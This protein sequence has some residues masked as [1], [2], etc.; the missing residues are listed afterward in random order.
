VYA[1]TDSVVVLDN[2]RVRLKTFHAYS[3]VLIEGN[4]S[5]ITLQNTSI[6]DAF[7]GQKLTLLGEDTVFN[8]NRVVVNGLWETGPCVVARG[9][10]NTYVFQDS[11]LDNCWACDCWQAKDLGWYWEHRN[12][13]YGSGLDLQ[14]LDSDLFMDS[15]VLLRHFSREGGGGVYVAG[16]GMNATISNTEMYD[17]YGRD[18]GGGVYF[19]AANSALQISSTRIYRNSARDQ[20]TKG[21]GILFEPAGAASTMV[22]Q[23]SE[24][25][26]NIAPEGGGVYVN[27]PRNARC[28]VDI[29]RT[30]ITNNLAGTNGGGLVVDAA[31]GTVRVQSC[32]VS[33]NQGSIGGGVHVIDGDLICAETTVAENLASQDGGGILFFPNNTDSILTLTGVTINNN[34]ALGGRGGGLHVGGGCLLANQLH[35]ISNTAGTDGGGISVNGT[36]CYRRTTEDD[37]QYPALRMQD[38][39][40]Q[41]NRA[42]M[43]GGGVSVRGMLPAAALQVH[44]VNGA[45][46]RV[47]LDTVYVRGLGKMGDQRLYTCNV[48]AVCTEVYAPSEDH[49]VPIAVSNDGN[50]ILIQRLYVGAEEGKGTFQAL[51]KKWYFESDVSYHEE[52]GSIRVPMIQYGNANSDKYAKIAITDS[53]IDSVYGWGVTA[54]VLSS[55][56]IASSLFSTVVLYTQGDRQGTFVEL[57]CAKMVL[58]MAVDRT[59]ELLYMAVYDTSRDSFA[60][61]VTFLPSEGNTCTSPPGPWEDGL[62]TF[63]TIRAM[64]VSTDGYT[65]FIAEKYVYCVSMYVCACVHACI[66]VYTD[67]YMLDAHV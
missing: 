58:A 43:D 27:C 7:E 63:G 1:S 35:V 41:S 20:Y 40:I 52:I 21:G 30:R 66:A 65:L 49:A 5:S 54:V 37:A 67:E 32:V 14:G 6:E 31:V 55:Q 10:R 23:D 22:L 2:V 12:R 46:T 61:S 42:Y 11:V 29:T 8:M 15:T 18:G 57:P 17:N 53:N 33:G 24:V 45:A 56:I 36:S 44:K 39:V 48:A 59:E 62:N 26:A 3:A 4:S 28:D 64:A 38:S 19:V 50:V 25:N 13:G 60:L 16:T 9:E 34:T 47:L 51:Q